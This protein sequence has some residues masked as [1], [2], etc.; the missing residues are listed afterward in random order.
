MYNIMI[1]TFTGLQI[2]ELKRVLEEEK[3]RL[4]AIKEDHIKQH[5]MNKN[6]I[7]DLKQKLAAS[8]V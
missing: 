7:Q 1:E 6:Q 2:A 5:N 4:V 3:A 8:E